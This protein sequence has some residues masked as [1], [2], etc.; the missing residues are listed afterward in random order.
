VK[1][2]SL[3]QE[4]SATKPT[5]EDKKNKGYKQAAAPAAVETAVATQWKAFT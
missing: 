5:E 1:G 3:S 4:A 2:C